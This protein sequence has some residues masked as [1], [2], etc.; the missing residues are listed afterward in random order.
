MRIAIL[1]PDGC[2]KTTLALNLAHYYEKKNIKVKVYELRRKILP[3]LKKIAFYLGLKKFNK[4]K[5]FIKKK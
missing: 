2:G 1:G 3:E 4:K 5:R